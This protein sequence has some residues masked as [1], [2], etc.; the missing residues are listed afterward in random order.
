[1]AKI[2]E[3]QRKK[4]LEVM[5]KITAKSKFTKKDI[6]ELSEKIK[7]GAAKRFIEECKT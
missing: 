4:D 1:M 2:S 6:E 3:A 7:R 5:N